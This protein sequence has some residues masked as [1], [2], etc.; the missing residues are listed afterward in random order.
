VSRCGQCGFDLKAQAA[1]AKFKGTVMMQPGAEGLGRTPATP[2]RAPASPAATPGRVPPASALKG[3]MVGV[4]PPD[5]GQ[6]AKGDPARP[7][8]SAAAAP[9]VSPAQAKAAKLMKGTMVGVAPPSEAYPSPTAPV[10]PV[11]KLKGTMIGVAPPDV[12]AEIAAA[13]ARSAAP[14]A[15]RQAS[16][17]VGLAQPPLA[18]PPQVETE[19]EPALAKG[20]PSKLKGTMI[21]VAPPDVQAEIA[22]AKARYLAGQ[23][24]DPPGDPT[25]LLGSAAAEVNPLGGTMLGTSPIRQEDLTPNPAPMRPLPIGDEEEDPPVLAGVPARSS[26]TGPLF[27]LIALVVLAAVT[28]AVLLV[29]SGGDEKPAATPPVSAQ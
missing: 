3:T 19:P 10:E 15:P 21:G 16:E 7:A 11:P 20:P 24:D 17:P 22:A 9:A 5:L 18:P 6:L 25:P 28:V 14:H 2:A 29:R 27:L 26:S 8:A 4:A 1:P 23:T 12:Q 13:K